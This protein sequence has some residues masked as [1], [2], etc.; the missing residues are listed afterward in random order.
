MDPDKSTQLIKFPLASSV[1][2]DRRQMAQLL[3]GGAAL[4]AFGKIAQAA[5]ESINAE[6]S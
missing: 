5:P 3:A 1:K 6:S 4:M 2:V